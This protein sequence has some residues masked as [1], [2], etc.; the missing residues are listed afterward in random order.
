S[1]AIMMILPPGAFITIG[2][3]LAILKQTRIIDFSGA[4][5]R[6]CH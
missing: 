1:P 5:E 6:G 3:I 4:G 2:V